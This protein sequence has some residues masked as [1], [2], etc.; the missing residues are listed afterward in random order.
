M[1]TSKTFGAQSTPI[2]A[3]SNT[4]LQFE[5]FKT[6]PKVPERV[7]F[8]DFKDKL[9]NYSYLL[10]TCASK[11]LIKDG[12]LVHGNVLRS[13][14]QPDSHLWVCLVNMYAK[15]GRFEWARY[16]LDKMPERDVVSW[17]A[18]VAGF[19][20]QGNGIEAVSL[21]CDMRRDGVL[22]NG[23]TF[24]TVLKACSMCLVLELGKQMHGE[25]IKL[26]LLADVYVGSALVDLYAK[27]SETGL[28]E[29]VL[30][31]MPEQNAVSWNALLN[32]YAQE[33][34]GEEVLKLFNRMVESEMRFSKYTL[35]SVLKGCASS[36]NAREGKGIHSLVVKIGTELDCFLSSSLADMYSKCGMTE[37]AYKV[38]LRIE[39]P[40]VVSWS[41]MITCLDQQGLN[42]EAAK[43]FNRMRQTG[44][45]PN[46]FTLA[47]VVCTASALDDL[48]YGD[49]VHACVMKLGFELDNS[50]SNALITM[51]M[52]ARSIQDGC[53][54]FDSMMG[55]DLVSWNS[56]L[57][58]FHD[59][60][61]C[62]QGPQIF[63]QILVE[64]FKPNNYTFIS[65]LRSCS[66]LSDIRF[67]QQL[68]GHVV[69][70]SLDSDGFVGTALVDMYS[71]CGCLESA[72]GVFQ[73]VKERDVFA[74]T[75]IITGY[76]NINQ[77]EMSMKYF[78][79]MQREGVCPNE[80]TLASCLRGC[81]GIAAL[82]NGRQLHSQI[83][84]AGQSDD[85]FIASALVDLYGK[86]GC[87]KD[88]EAV[89]SNLVSRDIVSWNSFICGYAQYGYG[90]KALNAFKGMLDEG[91]TPDEITFIGVLSA[92]SHVGLIKE[93][94]Y[95]FES[96]SKVYGITPTLKHYACMVDI[97]GRAGR[98]DEVQNF[99][100]KM[101]F[102]P[103]SLIWQTVLG[104]CVRHGN[105][106][107]AEKAAEELFILEPQMDSTYILL[108]NI[109][110]AKRRW[111]D[112][113]KVRERMSSQGVKKEP[114]CS[115]VEIDGQV[116][117]FGSRDVSHPN[118][119]EI[120]QK[121]DEMGQELML[122]GYV[123]DTDS[124]LHNV[125]DA[126]DVT[127]Y[128]GLRLGG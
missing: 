126:K 100:E 17:T 33:G 31:C 112:V 43:L 125:S 120:Y 67:G 127:A 18:L 42:Y 81:S 78:R 3:V 88:V 110:A 6:K 98:L 64:G 60:D 2:H 73:K 80:S 52:K 11:G 48:Q 54:V 13:G 75:V 51:Y 124:V 93:G 26:G 49:C 39:S 71:K 59:G 108:S 9:R 56:L 83:I 87:I 46:Q 90:E 10:Q 128:L 30:F 57:S 99:I 29:N 115:W 58:G 21:Y 8:W 74:W 16:L 37:D 95:H 105:V 119:K 47:S 106:E 63:K 77:G 19:V 61:S 7:K 1:Y 101:P 50:V 22:P 118:V 69:K 91:V 41:A 116:H 55:Q 4:S 107:M 121:L 38:F 72:H 62:K 35:S 28:A 96:M 15:C 27:C 122:A 68:H 84:K 12:K 104:A 40:D 14:L 109:Y 53:R 25:V 45:R 103:D 123:P 65:I 70:N 76:A 5:R 34:D 20:S 44:L 117:V 82:E 79:Q 102:A 24:A 86:C 36:G 23:F 92:C 111:D 97:L 113:A 66:S 89:F 85:A 94:K 114:G 32:G